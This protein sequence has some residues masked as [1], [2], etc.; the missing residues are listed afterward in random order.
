MQSN[1]T[2]KI[3]EEADLAELGMLVSEAIFA[4][5]EGDGLAVSDLLLKMHDAIFPN[6]S[7]P[8]TDEENTAWAAVESPSGV[9]SYTPLM[10]NEADVPD[11]QAEASID[12]LR[13]V[14]DQILDG[15]KEPDAFLE[16]LEMTWKI[17][18]D[19]AKAMERVEATINQ[20]V[21]LK[22]QNLQ[23]IGLLNMQAIDDLTGSA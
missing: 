1:D 13:Q 20:N 15:E 5:E 18:H 21:A 2:F 23:L 22:Q 6:A 11:P 19:C 8:A 4:S 7:R 10:L 17:A 9:Q 14:I 16:V 3:N 12:K